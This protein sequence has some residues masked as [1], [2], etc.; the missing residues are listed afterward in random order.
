MAKMNALKEF[1][2]LEDSLNKNPQEETKSFQDLLREKREATEK[3]L[4]GNKS[5]A[6]SAESMEERKKRL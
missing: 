6:P 2:D 5:N 3:Q 1:D 4:E